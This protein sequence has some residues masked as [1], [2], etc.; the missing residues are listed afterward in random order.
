[1]LFQ[2]PWVRSQLW[3]SI[4]ITKWSWLRTTALQ[5]VLYAPAGRQAGEGV[6]DARASFRLSNGARVDEER[7]VYELSNRAIITINSWPQPVNHQSRACFA[8]P[9]ISCRNRND[10]SGKLRRRSWDTAKPEVFGFALWTVQIAP[11]DKTVAQWGRLPTGTGKL[12][13]SSCAST[14]ILMIDL[15]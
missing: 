10:A 14:V 8:V 2:K 9:L 13:T 5:Y 11:E 15:N 12:W 7:Q 6:P 1:M 4:K 3:G